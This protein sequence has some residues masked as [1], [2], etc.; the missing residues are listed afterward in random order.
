[1]RS[2]TATLWTRRA[3]Q[4]GTDL[5][6]VVDTPGEPQ[7]ALGEKVE[8]S[9]ASIRCSAT[10]GASTT[11]R[12]TPGKDRRLQGP[13]GSRSALSEQRIDVI[14]VEAGI[15]RPSVPK[16]PRSVYRL[17]R[18]PGAVWLSPARALSRSRDWPR[19]LHRLRR[20]NLVFASDRVLKLDAW[21][22]GYQVAEIDGEL[23][24]I[25]IP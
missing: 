8:V 13:A 19:G 5:T 23:Q 18:L 20:S 24:A 16:A 25:Q 14:E 21:S 3:C 1:M 2:E 10:T 15:Q 17:L 12:S 7:L 9:V 4:L 11:S 6:R 22:S